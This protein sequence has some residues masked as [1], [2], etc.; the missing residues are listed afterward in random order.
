MA[1]SS[2]DKQFIVADAESAKKIIRALDNPKRIVAQQKNLENE[3]HEGLL[4]LKRKL[5]RLKGS[6]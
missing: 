2:F 1:T 3:E 4:A 5:A 6:L